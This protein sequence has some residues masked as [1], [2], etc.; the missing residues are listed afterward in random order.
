MDDRLARGTDR[1]GKEYHAGYE[2]FCGRPTRPVLGK[3]VPHDS[4]ILEVSRAWLMTSTL[5]DR[6]YYPVNIM[7]NGSWRILFR[8]DITDVRHLVV[9]PD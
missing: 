5:N 8:D 7:V 4:T 1:H 2:A 6:G 9:F 3:A